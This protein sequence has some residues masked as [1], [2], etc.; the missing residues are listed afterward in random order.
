MSTWF[1][2]GAFVLAVLVSTRL[3]G[4]GA[5]EEEMRLAHQKEA[6]G[7]VNTISQLIR[8]AAT[9]DVDQQNLKKARM[10][11]QRLRESIEKAK[12]AG[13]I[14]VRDPFPDR[15]SEADS[16]RADL[17]GVLKLILHV[18]STT[19]PA[20]AAKLRDDINKALQDKFR[21]RRRLGSDSAQELDELE[22]SLNKRLQQEN[23]RLTALRDLHTE[24][25]AV[26]ERNALVT[27]GAYTGT[28]QVTPGTTE[29]IYHL[30][31]SDSPMR[32]K[33]GAD[34]GGAFQFT[35]EGPAV[36]G[37]MSWG[38]GKE[39]HT[40][41]LEGTYDPAKRA[42]SLKVT[43]VSTPEKTYPDSLIRNAFKITGKLSGEKDSQVS[44][45]WTMQVRPQ[46]PLAVDDSGTNIEELRGEGTWKGTKRQ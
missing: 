33:V 3:F 4:Q 45:S 5:R 27:E 22:H 1:R 9:T 15:I 18:R 11:I 31:Q 32:M 10:Q 28:F 8:P 17:G 39:R 19:D 16:R 12:G 24:F 40:A 2:R 6:E 23:S 34:F 25:Q 35:I 43:K 13:G 44:G 42:V 14:K 21:M 7:I 30:P 26:L 41:V 37:T 46:P 29:I 20:D 38:E 36:K